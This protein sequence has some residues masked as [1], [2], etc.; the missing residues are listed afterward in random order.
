ME[1]VLKIINDNAV[2]TGNLCGLSLVQVSKRAK[3]TIA[4]ARQI[5][6]QIHADKK[7]RIREGIHGKLVFAL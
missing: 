1:E 5:L 4:E 3:L 6:N 7:I 2:A